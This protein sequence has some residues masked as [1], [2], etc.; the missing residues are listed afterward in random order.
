MDPRH[1]LHSLALMYLKEHG[2]RTEMTQKTLRETSGFPENVVQVFQRHRF[3]EE[4]VLV[5]NVA[6]NPFVE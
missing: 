4:P 5:I 3:G 6:R 2:D 1:V